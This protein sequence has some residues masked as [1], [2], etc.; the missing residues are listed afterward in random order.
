MDFATKQW[1]TFQHLNFLVAVS[2]FLVVLAT[3]QFFL[4]L[5]TVKL[6]SVCFIADI[7]IVLHS[8]GSNFTHYM[9]V[10]CFDMSIGLLLLIVIVWKTMYM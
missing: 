1:N 2:S 3:Q 8:I 4:N 5:K 9:V 10:V 6:W 7:L